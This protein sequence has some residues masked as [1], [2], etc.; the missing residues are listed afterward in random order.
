MT[1][2]IVPKLALA[3]ANN[4]I[5][6]SKTKGKPKLKVHRGGKLRYVLALG[7]NDRLTLAE[8]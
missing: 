1:S 3:S 2:A 8:A 5:K 4:H 7:K 6:K